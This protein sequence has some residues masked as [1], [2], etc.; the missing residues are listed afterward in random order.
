M[1]GATPKQPIIVTHLGGMQFS[2]QVRGHRIVV[3]QPQNTGG[4]D[5]APTPIELL[6][7]SLGCCIAFYVREFC[8]SRSLPYLGMSVE[9]MPQTTAGRIDRFTVRVI[10]P[11]PLP[12][13]ETELLERVA[14]SCPAHATL[15]HGADI[16]LGIE[17]PVGAA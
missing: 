12:A 9:V 6:T 14:R 1:A 5:S 16:A 15:A 3:D 8:R 13:R 2:A 11:E 7:S 17:V 4:T 10:M